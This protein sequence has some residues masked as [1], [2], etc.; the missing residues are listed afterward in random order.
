M[1]REN[2]VALV[3]GFA[4]VL[5]V[6]IL[7]SDHLSKA[8][9][10]RSAI[11]VPVRNT[12]STTA[13]PPARFVDLRTTLP[14]HPP[15]PVAIDPRRTTAQRATSPAQAAP[16]ERPVAVTVASE[17][18]Y[19][20]R[21]GE[22]LSTICHQTYGTAALTAALATHN[23]ISDPDLV[24]AGQRLRLPPAAVLT[25][26]GDVAISPATRDEID[27][28]T[29]WAAYRIKSGDSLSE[30]A[31]E[32]MGSAGHW[33]QLYELNRNAISDP[34]NIRAGTMLR[35]PSG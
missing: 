14:S 19:E 28:P 9:T 23:G 15:R 20:V 30:I 32:F 22:S 24:R 11:L 13:G 6:G 34:D 29:R 4:L 26:A 18:T 16:V 35:V 10:Q 21:S 8:Q 25:D 33:R 31:R 5:F 27:T 2:K 7:V 12:A 17:R 1:T 3:V